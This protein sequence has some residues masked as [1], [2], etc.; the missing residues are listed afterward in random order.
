MNSG[1]R[2]MN[3]WIWTHSLV[4]RVAFI[5]SSCWCR[6]CTNGARVTHILV[7]TARVYRTFWC[8]RRVHN[9]LAGTNGAC[10]THF[11]VQM[12]REVLKVLEKTSHFR[13]WGFAM[14]AQGSEFQV[15]CAV[16]RSSRL[17][18][19][20]W[21]RVGF[22]VVRVALRVESFGFRVWGSGSGFR[23]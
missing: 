7:H 16:F 9:T 1:F 8:K 14:R 10:I 6:S 18:A 11:L 13:S 2:G 12:A 20:R 21:R 17:C 3:S 15:D 4:A 19:F 23:I 5:G 22:Q